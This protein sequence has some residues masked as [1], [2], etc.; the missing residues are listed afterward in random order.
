M[1]SSCRQGRRDAGFTLIELLV[2]IAI[3]GLLLA[4]IIPAL[5][6]AKTQA[7][8]IVCMANVR[9]LGASW[10]LYAEDNDN[11]IMDGDTGDTLS[12]WSTYKGVQVHNFVSRPQNAAGAYSNATIEDKVRGFEKGAV[13]PYVENPDVYHCPSDRRYLRPAQGGGG[14]IGGYR[15]Y[16]LGAVLSL[17]GGE[18][19]GEADCQIRRR[20]EVISPSEK[21]TWLEEMDGWGYNNRTWN[22]VL[23]HRRWTDPFAIWHN[24]RSTFAFADGHAEKHKWVEQQTLDMAQA[25]IDGVSDSEQ[26]KFKDVLPGQPRDYDWAKKHY[27]PGST[28]AH[29]RW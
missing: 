28:P 8:A 27:I 21:F 23:T 24:G 10:Y 14:G 25:M 6:V 16:S 13:W 9:G 4:I 22:M 29:L 2:V 15:S 3:I 17:W 7:T 18:G 1:E 11:Y 12:G 26:V 19:S 5:Q 20:D